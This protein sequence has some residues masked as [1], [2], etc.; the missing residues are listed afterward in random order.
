MPN[1]DHVFLAQT[2]PRTE[3]VFTV[4]A[5]RGQHTKAICGFAVAGKILAGGTDRM[6]VAIIQTLR[7]IPKVQRR[8]MEFTVWPESFGAEESRQ[9][10]RKYLR[11]SA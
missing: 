9:E 4:I 8:A 10:V 5:D 2:P 3:V 11:Q 1:I 6:V 7:R